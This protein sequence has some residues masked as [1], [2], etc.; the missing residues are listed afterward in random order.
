M[1][2]FE[3]LQLFAD[4]GELDRLAG[5]GFHAQGRAAAGVAIELGQNR[6]GDVQRLDRNAWRR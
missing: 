1:K 4:A 3:V 2:R 5:D 6:A